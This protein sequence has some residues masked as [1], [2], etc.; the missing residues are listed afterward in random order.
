MGVSPRQL[1]Q[2]TNGLAIYESFH[3]WAMRIDEHINNA[4]EYG[5]VKIPLGPHKMSDIVYQMLKNHYIESGWSTLRKHCDGSVSL[6]APVM[7]PED[8]A[9]GA[10]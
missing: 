10:S 4:S 9:R 2:K 7:A 6:E 8:F 3:D 1:A 5:D